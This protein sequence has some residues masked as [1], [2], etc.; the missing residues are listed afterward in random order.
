MK[1]ATRQSAST[2]LTCA[3]CS[4]SSRSEFSSR[5][6]SLVFCAPTRP[7]LSEISAHIR[8]R[9]PCTRGLTI[10]T[11]RAPSPSIGESIAVTSVFSVFSVAL[12]CAVIAAK[13]GGASMPCCLS[14]YNARRTSRRIAPD[15]PASISVSIAAAAGSAIIPSACAIARSVTP[16]LPLSSRSFAIAS[17]GAAAGSKPASCSLVSSGFVSGDLLK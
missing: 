4:S 16:G 6:D 3:R 2:S 5:R 13:G 14:L 17:E 8:S 15:A 7:S 1:S 12:S 9:P 10:H 11:I